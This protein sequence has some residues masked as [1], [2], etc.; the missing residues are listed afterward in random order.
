[1]QRTLLPGSP[2]P[3]GATPQEEGTNF[4]V[5][6]ESATGVALCFFDESGKQ[7]DCIDLHERTAFI[8]HGF[9]KGIGSGQM[10]GYRIQ[11]PWEPE[12]GKRFESSQAGG[13]PICQGDYGQPGLESTGI[14]VRCREWRRPANFE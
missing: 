14:F 12:Q 2:Y 9:I 6:S 5:Y 10:Y 13:G 1:M 11:G 4:S 8:W 7:T 3:L